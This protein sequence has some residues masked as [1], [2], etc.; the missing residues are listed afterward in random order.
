[1]GVELKGAVCRTGTVN[2][3][4]FCGYEDGKCLQ[5]TF[6]APDFEMNRPSLG[7]WYMQ[8]TKQQA[9]ELAQALVEFADGT[10]EEVY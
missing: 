9:R 10:R 1:M 3:N 5:L 2:M 6:R 8:L 7:I 4:S